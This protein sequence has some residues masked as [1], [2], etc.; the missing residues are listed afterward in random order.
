MHFVLL[1]SAHDPHAGWSNISGQMF[2]C[3]ERSPAVL[4]LELG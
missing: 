2:F 4:L 3:T 1:E